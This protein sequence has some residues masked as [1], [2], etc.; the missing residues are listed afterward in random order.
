MD[1]IDQLKNYSYSMESSGKN[2]ALLRN[3]HTKMYEHT[4]NTSPLPLKIIQS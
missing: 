4:I 3:K 1:K 2:Q